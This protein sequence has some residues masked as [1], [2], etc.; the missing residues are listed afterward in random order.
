MYMPKFFFFLHPS[1]SMI[2][3]SHPLVPLFGQ[4]IIPAPVNMS[5]SLVV[6][7]VENGQYANRAGYKTGMGYTSHHCTN[8]CLRMKY[9]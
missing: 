7:H 5:L 6:N 4:R 2:Q 3:Y 1:M 9:Y 8:L